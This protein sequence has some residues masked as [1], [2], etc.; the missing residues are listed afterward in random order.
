MDFAVKT[1]RYLK[2]RLQKD[3]V[4]FYGFENE[5]AELKNL[6]MRTAKEG[7]SNSAILVSQ[8]GGGK[9]L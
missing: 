7:E 6:F 8:K 1:R 3:A 4:T 9:Q 5:R 2:E